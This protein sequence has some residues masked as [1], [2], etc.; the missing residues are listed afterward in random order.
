M[1]R[2]FCNLL[3]KIMIEPRRNFKWLFVSIGNGG[4]MV[5][6]Q[7]TKKPSGPKKEPPEL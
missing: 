1:R 7:R 6:W 2:R 4:V 5:K 3:R